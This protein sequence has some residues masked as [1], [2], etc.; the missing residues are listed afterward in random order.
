[1]V[2]ATTVVPEGEKKALL[3]DR[4]PLY[5]ATG[6]VDEGEST[7]DFDLRWRRSKSLTVQSRPA[8]IME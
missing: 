8:E 6:G 5:W 4:T 3:M 7:E 2:V 1:M